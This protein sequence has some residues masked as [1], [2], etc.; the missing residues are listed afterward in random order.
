[1]SART[2]DAFQ[3]RPT[4]ALAAGRGA[5]PTLIVLL[6]AGLVGAQ[7]TVTLDPAGDSTEQYE[8][9]H[10]ISEAGTSPIDQ[11]RALSST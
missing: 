3:A 4:R 2:A 10:A 9:S 8:L 7:T 6:S 11:I 1:M 5:C